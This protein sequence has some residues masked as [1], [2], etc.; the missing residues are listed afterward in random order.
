MFKS[1]RKFIEEDDD[2]EGFKSCNDVE[3]EDDDDDDDAMFQSCR[4]FFQKE[5][6]NPA[7]NPLTLAQN[8]ITPKVP[9]S[10]TDI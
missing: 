3:V 5:D 7:K 10:K 1:C 6:N 2:D 4:K 8:D 9:I